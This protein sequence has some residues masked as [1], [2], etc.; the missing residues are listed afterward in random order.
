MST[1]P[2]PLPAAPSPA[3]LRARA[4]EGAGGLAGA[5]VPVVSAIAAVGLVIVFAV[6][7]YVLGAQMHRLVKLLIGMSALVGLVVNPTVGLF[8]LPIAAPML[9]L[10][11]KLPIPGVNTLNI[12]LL[13]LFTPFAIQR[14]FSRQPFMRRG[15]L[16]LP[17]MLLVI[18]LALSVLRGA[19]F[20]T[21]YVYQAGDAGLS[22]FR[23]FMTF[24]IYIIT[25]AIV[26]GDQA[27]RRM[28]WAIVLGALVESLYVLATG[29]GDHGRAGGSMH[30]ANE[31]GTF[32]SMFAA[33]SFAVSLGVRKV[34]QRLFAWGVVALSAFGVLLSVSRGGLVALALSVLWVT[35]RS[36]RWLTLII[37]VVLA[38][39]PMWLPDYVMDR[40]H[41]TTSGASDSDDEGGGLDP[42]AESRVNTW[43]TIL[44]I[45]QDHAIEGIGF[46]SLHYV[47]P[48]A[49]EEL[50]LHVKDSSHNSF[51]RLLAETGIFGVGL[52][53]FLFLRIFALAESAIR[54]SRDRFD[55]QLGVGL[56]AATLALIVSCAFGDRFFQIMISGNL[57]VACAV[58]DDLVHE[59]RGRTA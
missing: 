36:S 42:G 3:E 40:I 56:S 59:R 57:W 50:G 4:R 45:V 19:V 32:L 54:L 26:S 44:H 33:F 52:F 34:W 17:L 8:V 48:Q 10:L 51:L 5:A 39:S 6:L 43:H 29:R 14:V 11:P 53:L 7:D 18:V 22:V 35:W 2:R 46:E 41:M 9:G 21:G 24:T 37:V 15:S 23:C 20:P 55:R 16:T 49:G 27:R 30:Q 25:F 12:L 38:T 1:E 31:L 58:V 13:A 47:L 28:T